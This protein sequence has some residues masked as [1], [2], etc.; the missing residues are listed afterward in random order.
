VAAAVLLDDH[1]WCTQKAL[2]V[3]HVLTFLPAYSPN[4]NLIE[5]LGKLLRKHALQQW[6]ASNEAMLAVVVQVLVHRQ[7]STAG[8]FDAEGWILSV[9]LNVPAATGWHNLITGPVL[10]APT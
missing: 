6:H 2:G 3:E 4:L 8:P 9:R 1:K 7:D 5:W 10:K